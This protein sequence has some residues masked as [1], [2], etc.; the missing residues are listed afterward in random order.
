MRHLTALALA[1]LLVGCA[2]VAT[3][4]MATETS[5]PELK[6]IA[7]Y[8]YGQSREPVTIVEDMVREAAKGADGGEALAADLS[9]LLTGNATFDCKQFVCRQ[10][11]KIGTEANV[12][13]IAP[14]LYDDATV[15]IARFALQPIPGNSVDTVLLKALRS[16]PAEARIGI[17]NT[18]G[19]R[20]SSSTKGPLQKLAGGTDPKV[21]EA[22]KSAL[23][24]I[25]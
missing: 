24:K 11:A 18:L 2:H 8:A 22:A 14:L 23:A 19:I 16:G 3:K 21:A 7:M 15:D 5:A 9:T 1:V 25:G 17:I 4:P 6:A 20:G 12:P 13:S 10:L